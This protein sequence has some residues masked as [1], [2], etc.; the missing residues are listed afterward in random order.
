MV[1]M[2]R[3]AVTLA[4]LMLIGYVVGQQGL[5]NS[6]SDELLKQKAKTMSEAQLRGYSQK[7]GGKTGL[8]TSKDS[9]AARMD[10][11][12]TDSMAMEK[13]DSSLDI[14]V[15]EK[16]IRNINIDPE[17][18]LK[19]LP[20]FGFDVFQS[21]RMARFAP[22]SNLATPAD[23]SVGAG[24]EI[25]ILLWGRINE[26][27]QLKVDR[28]GKINIPHLGPIIVVGMPFSAMQKNILDRLQAIEGVQASVSLGELRSIS[29]FIVGEVK[30][31]G[32][33]TV[34]ALSNVANA[35]FAAGGP[36]KRGSL[37]SVQLKRNGNLVATVDFYDFLLSGK[38]N[39]GLRLKSGDVIMV[40]VT[41]KMAAIAGNVRRSALYE[42]KDTTTLKDII[43]LAGG[44]TP[45]AW[46]NRIQIERFQN[47][48]FQI[49]LD[50]ETDGK[51][52]PMSFEIKDGDI[53]KI[54]PIV[55]KDKNVVYLQGNVYRP[56][57]Y[58]FKDGMRISDL[59]PEFQALLPETYFDY[60]MVIR[61][62]PPNF[63]GRI[64]PFNL[65]N[66]IEGHTSN[67]DV[68][69]QA[70][71]VVMV[72][73][74]DY[75]EPDRT[76]FIGGAV[77]QPG[78]QK[79][80][81]NMKVRDLIIKAGGLLEEASEERGE[82]YRRIYANN[83]ISTEKV[84]FNVRLAMNDDAK[85]NILLKKFD[86]ITIRSKKGWEQE[87]HVVLKGEI[88]YPGDYVLLGGETLGEIIDRAGG[89]TEN[90]YLP[91]ATMIRPSAKELEK[92]RV[93]E[94]VNQLESD[95]LKVSTELMVKQQAGD[96]QSLLTQQQAVLNKLR[97]A[98]P[99][100]RVVIDLTNKDAYKDFILE[101]GDSLY[102]PKQV[103]TV[104]V[105]G[106]VYNPATFRFE[107]TSAMVKDYIEM[108]GGVKENADLKNVYIF[109]ANGS[110][111]TRKNVKV[112]EYALSPADV[113]VVPQK[114]VLKNNFK[115]FMDTIDSI[116]KLST[117]LL[118]IATV[119][120][121]INQ[122]KN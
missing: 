80:F 56:G 3:H 122:M 60:A 23:Y 4:L 41:R 15:Y 85:Y 55:I 106:E 99:V 45:V 54:F 34:S 28:E 9:A 11:M 88:V 27:Y 81:E 48:Q 47:N 5:E 40:P 57:K 109:K 8:L 108:A 66:A 93:N 75:F 6:I 44:I 38:D 2:K 49:V 32:M 104:S 33:Y 83:I 71:D 65:K 50:I 13:K 90:A 118:S 58:E 77:T 117:L 87:K 24:D 82:L 35:L 116:T 112:M 86:V 51:K 43:A 1:T 14:S 42:I 39:S 105:I 92:K 67:D 107:K 46:T 78:K 22:E 114:V 102:V 120:I 111:L 59:L 73:S 84:E 36:N 113:V 29:V 26:T 62:E 121:L 74:R 110:I 101:N 16:L 19:N 18:I 119:L 76:V 17:K 7:Y 94:Y 96:I 52:P 12:A 70:R 95:A 91:A 21:S 115:I 30:S 53:V 68:I 31:P 69:L 61:Q 103:G 72:Y 20:I 98:D 79:L 63:L 89:F 64:I 97:N 100:G 10:T 37:R 25:N